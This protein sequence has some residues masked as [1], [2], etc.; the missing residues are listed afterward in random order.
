M[1]YLHGVANPAKAPNDKQLFHCCKSTNK[2]FNF[3][4]IACIL[5]MPKVY[6]SINSR[7]DNFNC[8]QACLYCFSKFVA[9]Y[10]TL[11]S[12]LQ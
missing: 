9:V 12:W 4:N 11:G 7:T 10:K 5:L 3:F 6:S 1:I 2:I 8:L